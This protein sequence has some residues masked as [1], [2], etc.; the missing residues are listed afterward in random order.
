MFSGLGVSVCL[1]E[2]VRTYSAYSFASGKLRSMSISAALG[3]P[4]LAWG[5]Q[6]DASWSFSA[7]EFTKSTKDSLFFVRGPVS[8]ERSCLLRAAVGNGLDVRILDIFNGHRTAHHIQEA[9]QLRSTSRESRSIFRNPFG[10]GFQILRWLMLRGH[11]FPASNFWSQ[12]FLRHLGA[13]V[14][15]LWRKETVTCKR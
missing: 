13:K 1:T 12:G 7:N 14:F 5:G 4:G 11:R 10:G 6:N 8:L 2:D 15:V 3:C 9:H